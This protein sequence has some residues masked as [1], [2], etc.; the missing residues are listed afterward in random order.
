MSITRQEEVILPRVPSYDDSMSKL[1]LNESSVTLTPGWIIGKHTAKR[2]CMVIYN[3]HPSGGVNELSER[4][5]GYI[6]GLGLW[7]WTM[8]SDVVS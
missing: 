5:N 1:K 2:N 3:P 7:S 6:D 4:A 8:M